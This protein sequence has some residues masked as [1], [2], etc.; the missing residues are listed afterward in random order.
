[1]YVFF[2]KS[3]LVVI[4]ACEVA[5][6]PH[7]FLTRANQHIQ[8]INRHFYGTLNHFGPMVFAE[9]QEQH[10]YYTFKDMLLQPYYS[11]LIL[12][13][14]KEVEEHEA[15]S[16]WTL[17]K[18]SQVNNKHENKDGNINII[19]SIWYFNQKKIPIWDIIETQIH[20]LCMTTTAV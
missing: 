16:H 4:I 19:V 13:M 8:E 3:S 1:M 7:I 14:I 9:N 6:N 18:N 2:A 11:D 20:N 5:K 17:M 15:R 12:A 10:F